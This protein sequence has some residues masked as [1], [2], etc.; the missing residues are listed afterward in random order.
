MRRGRE[1]G[2]SYGK[3]LLSN[4]HNIVETKRPFVALKS[5][6]DT[7]HAPEL[8]THFIVLAY[9]PDSNAARGSSN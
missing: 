9:P 6:L 2:R 3:A 4:T 1:E 5:L 7:R 8:G